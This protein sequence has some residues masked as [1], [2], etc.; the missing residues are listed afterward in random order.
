MQYGTCLRLVNHMFGDETCD[1]CGQRKRVDVWSRILGAHV[2]KHLPH[3]WLT[4]LRTLTV[5][6]WQRS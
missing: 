2:S 3:L 1:L 4:L 5:H 6:Q